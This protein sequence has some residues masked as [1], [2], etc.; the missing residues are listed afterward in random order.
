M[1]VGELRK[2]LAD[3]C[4]GGNA[5]LPVVMVGG[6]DGQFWDAERVGVENDV[7]RADCDDDGQT[8][9]YPRAVVL[10]NVPD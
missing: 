4:D 3:L 5:D 9:T 8:V 1:T 2:L 7:E 6:E 10:D